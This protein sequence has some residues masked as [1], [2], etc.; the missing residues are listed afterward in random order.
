MAYTTSARSQST[1]HA[2]IAS[3]VCEAPKTASM[4][5]GK[6]SPSFRP[7]S[8]VSVKRASSS[9][10][11]SPGP[12]TCTSSARTGSVGARLAPSRTAIGMVSPSA[13]APSSA[14]PAI[15]TGMATSSMS[16]V[17]RQAASVSGR[18]SFTPAPNSD[19]MTANSAIRVRISG[20][21]VGSNQPASAMRRP[22]PM[23]SPS[24]R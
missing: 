7:A 20:S 10:S 22:A 17:E 6:A 8:E 21:S 18:S 9:I 19:T 23:A 14:T 1:H 11:S 3:N 5:N 16:S 24:T 12:V 13:H 2:L 4:T 15:V